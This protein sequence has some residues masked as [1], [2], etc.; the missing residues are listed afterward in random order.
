[1]PIEDLLDRAIETMRN[2]TRY[3]PGADSPASRQARPRE[4]VWFR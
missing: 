2:V 4:L 1:M 3:L